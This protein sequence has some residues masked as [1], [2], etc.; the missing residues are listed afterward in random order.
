MILST[1]A[2]MENWK[3]H[4]CTVGQHKSIC[5]SIPRKDTPVVCL[6]WDIIS[7]RNTHTAHLHIGTHAGTNIETHTHAVASV[8]IEGFRPEWCISTVYYA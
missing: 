4:V 1:Y 6:Q 3:S 8:Q 2:F 5:T 7:Y